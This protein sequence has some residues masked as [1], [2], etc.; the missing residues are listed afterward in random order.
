MLFIRP[1]AQDDENRLILPSIDSK[2]KSR[3]HKKG[4]LGVIK[5]KRLAILAVVADDVDCAADTQHELRTKPMCVR[6]AF[7]AT[8]QT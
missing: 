2:P 6:P 8:S 5:R 3:R 1:I 4:Q 7:G